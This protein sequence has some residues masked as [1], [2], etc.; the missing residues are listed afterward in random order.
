MNERIKKLWVEALRSGEYPQTSGC[1]RDGKGFCCL[2]VLCDLFSKE[3]G[4]NW[5]NHH[6]LERSDALPKEVSDW[7]GLGIEENP[8]IDEENGLCAIE[9][10][11]DRLL[12]FNQISD[13]VSANL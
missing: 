8:V 12:T 10:N 4:Q 6:F 7:A 5:D 1:L 11:D 13:L 3:T 9:A 2:G